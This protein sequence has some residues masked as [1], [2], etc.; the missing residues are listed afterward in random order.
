MEFK[1]YYAALGVTKIA[2]Q[3]EIQRAY[4]KLARKYHPDVNK[5][6]DAPGIW[7]HWPHNTSIPYLLPPGQGPK[8][9]L[10]ALAASLANS[11]LDLA[12]FGLLGFRQAQG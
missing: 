7:A 5:T 8:R 1:D 2:P 9:T 11:H 10:P 3:E 12:R 4:R 6:S